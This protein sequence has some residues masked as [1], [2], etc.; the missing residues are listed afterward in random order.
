MLGYNMNCIIDIGIID[1]KEQ[2][3]FSTPDLI[4][5][6]ILQLKKSKDDGN[7]GFKI[8]S[9]DKWGASPTCILIYVIQCYD[10]SWL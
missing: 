2:G 1:F 7:V 3:M 4:H 10:H 6:S 8:R 5:T 9:F